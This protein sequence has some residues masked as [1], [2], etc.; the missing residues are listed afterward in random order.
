MAFITPTPLTRRQTTSI[1][2]STTK[3]L[4]HPLTKSL[5]LTKKSPTA[6]AIQPAAPGTNPRPRT[7]ATVIDSRVASRYECHHWV[8]V[9]NDSRRV[10]ERAAVAQADLARQLEHRQPPLAGA[11][12]RWVL[13]EIQN[14]PLNNDNS[15][16]EQKNHHHVPGASRYLV[17]ESFDRLVW[18]DTLSPHHHSLT[19]R[20][21][22]AVERVGPLINAIDIHSLQ[23][24]DM[25]TS[26]VHDVVFDP[27]ENIV[28]LQSI[29]VRRDDLRAKDAVVDALRA[30]A[31]RSVA[32][33]ACMEF[34]ILQSDT[35]PCLFKT[36]EIFSNMDALVAYADGID[37]MFE[38]SIQ[39]HVVDN[40]HIRQVFKPVVFS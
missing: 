25:F 14:H 39:P 8:V 30:K 26:K 35:E 16:S 28:V 38:Q 17:T 33:G 7:A 1:T 12:H 27:R 22:S 32:V 10:F 31:E 20:W 40:R 18:N 2:Q 36:V 37:K 15:S 3:Q 9:R 6:T 4:R 24:S 29:N 13:R 19:R 23:Y 34:G 5:K 11:L 21:L